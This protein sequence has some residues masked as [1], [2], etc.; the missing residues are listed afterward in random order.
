[1]PPDLATLKD[2]ASNRLFEAQASLVNHAVQKIGMG[3]YQWG[4]FIVAGYGWMCDQLWQT[5]V[6]DALAPIGAE[7]DPVHETFLSLGL[8]SGLILGAWFWG[9]GCDLIGR[10][11]AFNTTLF[12][13]GVFGIAV[14]GANSFVA[15][16]SLCACV[17]F[18]IGGNL[19]VD[20]AIFLELMPATHQWLLEILSIWWSLGQIVPA[21]TAWGFL[22]NYSCPYNTPAGQCKK[23]DNMGWRYLVYTMGTLTMVLWIIRFFV[24]NLRE[25]PKYLIGQGRYI[26]AVEM[27]NSIA[28]YNKTT[29]PLNVEDFEQIERDFS[30]SHEVK[31]ASPKE[32]I[33]RTFT[34]QLRPNGFQH[35]RALFATPKLAY[36]MTLILLIWGMIGLASPLYSNFLPEFLAAKGAE[37]G[38]SSVAITYRNNLIIVVCSIPGTLLGG[39]LINVKYLGRKGTLGGS[40]ILSAIF[41]FAFTT[42]RTPAQIL[43]FNC[44]ANF[45]QY[46]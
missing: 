8:A 4:L 20:G 42:A 7:F 40:L 30:E 14:G 1:M 23:A 17:G 2:T 45:A 16:A 3:R 35:I 34:S 31:P 11:L 39:W 36:S 13:G 24:F 26:E 22:P 18:G 33:K 19:P 21:V 25:S 44:V 10:K 28:T 38:S 46:M 9:L 41:Q 15:A 32:A 6:A 27:L 5:T 12:I 29:Q 37:T 43:A